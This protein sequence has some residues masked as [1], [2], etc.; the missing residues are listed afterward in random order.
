MGIGDRPYGAP[1]SYDTAR[2]VAGCWPIRVALCRLFQTMF[3]E[4]A[5]MVGP[6][7]HQ[8]YCTPRQVF[9]SPPSLPVRWLA[10]CFFCPSV[11]VP[12][13]LLFGNDGVMELPTS[14]RKGS[15]L[16]PPRFLAAVLILPIV[17]TLFLSCFS[18]A[19]LFRALFVVF[20]LGQRRTR[21]MIQLTTSP[22]R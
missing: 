6:T 13:T 5:L 17:C 4:W 8:Q 1:K 16:P 21:S 7:S 10:F 3:F 14:S 15:L 20:R 9:A 12:L 11:V 2:Y 19:V 22:T 18:A